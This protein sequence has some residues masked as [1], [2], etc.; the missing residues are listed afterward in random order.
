VLQVDSLALAAEESLAVGGEK[1]A[2]T[3]IRRV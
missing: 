2:W 1:R 3:D